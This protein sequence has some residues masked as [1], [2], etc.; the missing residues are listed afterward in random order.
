MLR[1]SKKFYDRFEI[2]LKIKKFCVIKE[3]S[4][5][6]KNV[7]S[8]IYNAVQEA[9]RRELNADFGGHIDIV[10]QCKAWGSSD[11]GEVMA[12]MASVRAPPS[13]ASVPAA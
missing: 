13:S 11:I 2:F 3:M 12:N 10:K 6:F 9:I 8:K 1:S 5:Y 4:S 7:I